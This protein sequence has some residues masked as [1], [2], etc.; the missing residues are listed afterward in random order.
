MKY[1][2]K[3]AMAEDVRE[4]L[5]AEFEAEEIRE[6]MQEDPDEFRDK[7]NDELWVYDGVTGNASG[8]YTFNRAL[9]E[10]MVKDNLPLCIEAVQEF[11]IDAKEFGER[12]LN[13]E[14]EWLD[15]TIRC[16]L[17]GEAIS[18]VLEEFEE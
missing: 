9:A 2:Y 16:Y 10:E 4:Y 6:Q 5:E 14:W 3:K 8:S 12:V 7:L 1:D 15:V 11:C 18:E 17:L 13:E